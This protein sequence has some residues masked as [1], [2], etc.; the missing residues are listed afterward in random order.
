M[1][2]D[3]FYLGRSVEGKFPD[4]SARRIGSLTVLR[5]ATDSDLTES[6]RG[7]KSSF[8][9]LK[10]DCGKQVNVSTVRLKQPYECGCQRPA[11]R[12]AARAIGVSSL[13]RMAGNCFADLTGVRHGVKTIQRASTSDEI[14][15][16][17]VK[18][19]AQRWWLV[20]CE[21]GKQWHQRTGAFFASISCGC[22]REQNRIRRAKLRDL[23]PQTLYRNTMAH[24]VRQKGKRILDWHLSFDQWN[25]LRQ[26]AC[27]YC[28]REPSMT[29]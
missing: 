19:D 2:Q 11:R 23:A 3:V 6:Q 7:Q 16:Q 14:A 1:A 5:K 27:A 10:C 20:Q 9:V 26:G 4:L 21:C 17:P 12:N 8:W 24:C 13:Q 15:A 22:T 28:G 29:L 18:A 25:N